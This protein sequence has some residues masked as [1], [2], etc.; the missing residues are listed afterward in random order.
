MFQARANY[1]VPSTEPQ[2]FHIDVGGVVGELIAP[3]LKTTLIDVLD[4][5]TDEVSVD[6]KQDGVGF[7]RAPTGVTTFDQ[8]DDWHSE[9]N[10]ELA[11]LLR[12]EVGAQQVVVFDHT[13]RV[14]DPAAERRPA[15]HVHSD[16]SSK[17]AEQRLN[18]LLGASEAEVW[19]KGHYAFVNVWRPVGG[20]VLSAPLGFVLPSSVKAEDWISIDLLYPDRVGQIMGLLS[21]DAHRWVYRSN[22]TEDEVAFFRI[23]DNLGRAPVGH[24]ALDSAQGSG[25]SRIRKSI[26]SRTLI[27]Y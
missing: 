20:P 6:F 18:D 8:G 12:R 3:E 5:R 17:G 7:A 22:M 14:D 2:A 1:H 11:S 26:E 24:S 27:R 10:L 25:T 19:S 9:Y 13:F 4:E 21:N 15:R 23:Y 16:Y